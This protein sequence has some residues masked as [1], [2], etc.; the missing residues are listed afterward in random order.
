[1]E[2][3]VVLVFNYIEIVIFYFE[4]HSAT[5]C[6]VTLFPA[7][8]ALSLLIHIQKSKLCTCKT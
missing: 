5:T 7:G 2:V 6:T 4:I 3:T 8:R 1:M